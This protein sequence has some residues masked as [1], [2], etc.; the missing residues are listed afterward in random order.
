MPFG[1]L[2]IEEGCDLGFAE[3]GLCCRCRLGVLILVAGARCGRGDLP[4]R[5]VPLPWPVSWRCHRHPLIWGTL[6]GKE[7]AQCGFLKSCVGGELF[8]AAQLL[9][10]EHWGDDDGRLPPAV[11][12]LLQPLVE[13]GTEERVKAMS[14]PSRLLPLL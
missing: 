3:R 4:S 14:L 11:V 6:L 13:N 12:L 9:V 8:A 7:F 1:R 5:G 10:V 2:C